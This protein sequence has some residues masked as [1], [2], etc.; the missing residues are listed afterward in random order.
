MVGN[1]EK[2]QALYGLAFCFYV[3]LIVKLANQNQF[4]ET[5]LFYAMAIDL[6]FLGCVLYGYRIGFRR[7]IINTIFTALSLFVSL[8]AAFKFSPV[9]T[10]VLEQSLNTYTPLMFIG[11]FLITFFIARFL[12]GFISESITGVLEASHMNLTNEI[13]GGLLMSFLFTF[14]FSVLSW[15]ADGAGL[16]DAQ[17]QQTSKIYPYLA[18]LRIQTVASFNTLRPIFNDFFKETGRAMDQMEKKI[19]SNAPDKKTTIYDNPNNNSGN[20]NQ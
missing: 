5:K 13:F 16:I 12:I 1:N 7:G 9:M 8:I 3:S 2:K 17:T 20:N 10:R 4:T 19:D 11:G 18:P 15:F 6:L 14:V